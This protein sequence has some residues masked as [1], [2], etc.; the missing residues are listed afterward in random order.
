MY[1]NPF[2]D[3]LIIELGDLLLNSN[4]RI[5]CV[6]AMGQRVINQEIGTTSS[7]ILSTEHLSKGIY[8][9]HITSLNVN[10]VD[11]LIKY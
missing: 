5:E 4:G 3:Q 11:K 8:T 2:N 9:I 1:P 10:H 7:F 6:N